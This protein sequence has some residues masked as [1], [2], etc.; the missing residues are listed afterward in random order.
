MNKEV[1]K[2]NADAVAKARKQA[3]T[4]LS[5]PVLSL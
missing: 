5:A 4:I 1:R 3:Q 2:R